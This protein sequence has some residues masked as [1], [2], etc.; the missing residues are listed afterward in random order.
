M[1]LRLIPFGACYLD[2]NNLFCI[3]LN[4]S[5][6]PNNEHFVT[7]GAYILILLPGRYLEGNYLLGFELV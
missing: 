4:V 3:V 1:Q 5:V 6:T 7:S 2:L